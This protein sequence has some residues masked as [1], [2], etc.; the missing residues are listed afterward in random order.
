MIARPHKYG[1]KR[2]QALDGTWHPSIKQ[3]RRWD[4]L[5]IL[6]KAGV[7]SDLRREV[8]VILY[9]RDAPLLTP[10]G[11]QMTWRADAIYQEKGETI[12]EDSKGLATQL[13]LMKRAVLAAQGI[14]VRET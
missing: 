3:A 4:V 9:G 13:Y 7:I 5:C 10:K 6:Q 1:A 2:T 8:P 11:R 14:T 12:H